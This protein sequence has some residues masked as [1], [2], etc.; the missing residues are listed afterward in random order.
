MASQQEILAEVNERLSQT[1]V[2]L[3]RIDEKL[4]AV[5]LR[6]D[7]HQTSD[8]REFAEIRANFRQQD[9]RLKKLELIADGME[10]AAGSIAELENRVSTTE[11]HNRDRERD[12]Q[13]DQKWVRWIFWL[14]LVLVADHFSGSKVPELLVHL[15][16]P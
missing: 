10:S 5:I 2:T 4:K 11:Q 6:G 7:D 16:K 12:G 15:L 14:V 9:D 13:R 1:V 3:A 8:N